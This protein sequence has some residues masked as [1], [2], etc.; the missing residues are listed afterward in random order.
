M[1]TTLRLKHADTLLDSVAYSKERVTHATGTPNDNRSKKIADL[2][3]AEEQL[4]AIRRE[5][6]GGDMPPRSSGEG[7]RASAE[8]PRQCPF[9]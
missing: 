4:R 1:H 9:A 3:A 5:L 2:Q 6:Q 7:G 8:V